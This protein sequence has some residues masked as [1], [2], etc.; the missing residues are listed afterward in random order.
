M[1]NKKKLIG[2]ISGAL[3]LM[4]ICVIGISSCSKKKESSKETTSVVKL[5][6]LTTREKETSLK[7]KETESSTE[8]KTEPV[9]EVQSEPVTEPQTE[10][11]TEP[12][13][14]PQTEPITEPPTQAPTQASTQAPTQAPTEAPTKAAKGWEGV[15]YEELTGYLL[16]GR[17]KSVPKTDSEL[18]DKI[19][20]FQPR[21]CETYCFHN[22]VAFGISKPEDIVALY[23]EPRLIYIDDT[24]ADA[25]YT[26]IVYRYRYG[27]YT[28][29]LDE[30]IYIDF[31]FKR[32]I[33]N[34]V[35]MITAGGKT[36][37]LEDDWM[38][39]ITGGDWR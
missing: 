21:F 3:A 27:H 23:G 35:T 2:V 7:A 12:I 13:T 19:S 15:I 28:D 8:Q 26:Y 18:G 22:E 11:V 5:T 33:G 29:D 14:E 32:E 9:T 4:I 31:R 38:Y 24:T 6:E 39:G 20:N 34:A 30:Q 16:D 25:G 10:P 36:C 17:T 1:S 37:M